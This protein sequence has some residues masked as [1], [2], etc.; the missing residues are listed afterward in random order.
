[1]ASTSKYTEKSTNKYCINSRD[2]N[3]QRY[4]VGVYFYVFHL[5]Q[6]LTRR[7]RDG[8]WTFAM[9]IPS[10]SARCKSTS[11]CPNEL[12][13]RKAQTICRGSNSSI[14]WRRGRWLWRRCLL[15]S[16]CRRSWGCCTRTR[17]ASCSAIPTFYSRSCCRW[18]ICEPAAVSVP[19][20]TVH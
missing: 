8:Y 2:P 19:G 15:R 3:G 6:M 13:S 12:S 18:S 11:R 9:G 16:W 1:M 7:F 4:Y 20:A 14:L 10:A 17:S 5:V